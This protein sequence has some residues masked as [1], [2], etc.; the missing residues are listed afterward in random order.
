MKY[1]KLIDFHPIEDVIQ[2]KSADDA[3]TGRS[4][5]ESYVVS[6][7]M[8]ENLSNAMINQLQLDEVIDNKGV[9]VVG[10]YGTGKSHLMSVVSAI[11]SD[12]DNLPLLKNKKLANEMTSIA[13]RLV[14][15][16]LTI[17]GTS[18]PYTANVF[19]TKY[20]ARTFQISENKRTNVQGLH[21]P[22][23][24]MLQDRLG[25]ISPSPANVI[26]L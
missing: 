2:L 22:D 1:A 26:R 6:D 3:A 12:A 15:P 7:A 4:Y 8:A 19:P 14:G 13:G 16:A 10:N 18:M 11:A 20:S 25:M 17:S 23:A 9:L 24:K 21:R 5:V